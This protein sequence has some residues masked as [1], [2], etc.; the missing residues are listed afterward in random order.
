MEFG[1]A[2]D[3]FSYG[4]VLCEL[5]CRCT[6]ESN[7]F[8]RE[9]PG[10]GID[11]NTLKANAEPGHPEDLLALAIHCTR[12]DPEDRPSWS[13]ILAELRYIER[14]FPVNGNLGALDAPVED[15]SPD[16]EP[17]VTSA[18]IAI[19]D[20][21]LPTSNG[22]D[23][24]TAIAQPVK[25]RPR[26]PTQN[27]ISSVVTVL[28]ITSTSACTSVDNSVFD[29]NLPSTESKDVP[30]TDTTSTSPNTQ[31]IVDP[32]SKDQLDTDTSSLPHRF[33]VIKAPTM[34]KC[35]VCL[36]RLGIIPGSKKCMVCDGK[37]FTNI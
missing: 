23:T 35:A 30:K 26:F 7:R 19:T 31:P 2:V 36:R 33:S 22:D 28:P 13:D 17:T 8:I 14:T 34:T 29:T 16:S 4:V 20:N 3:I 6:V 27:S 9:I 1:T 24:N 12:A 21:S 5:V 37:H 11:V 18:T 10:F 25:S 15:T 32:I